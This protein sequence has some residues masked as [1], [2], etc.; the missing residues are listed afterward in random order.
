M[1]MIDD[2]SE[3]EEVENEHPLFAGTGSQNDMQHGSHWGAKAG[4]SQ[5]ALKG[6][7]QGCSRGCGMRVG[8]RAWEDLRGAAVQVHGCSLRCSAHTERYTFR[9][10]NCW[11]YLGIPS[12]W[13]CGHNGCQEWKVTRYECV[14]C[15]DFALLCFAWVLPHIDTDSSDWGWHSCTRDCVIGLR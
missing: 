6:L 9:E 12:S 2:G 15:V 3:M 8:S 10:C 13:P 1:I 14:M 4:G 5:Q 7:V 11:G